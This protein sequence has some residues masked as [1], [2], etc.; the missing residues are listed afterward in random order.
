MVHWRG[1]SSGGNGTSYG[2]W[3]DSICAPFCKEN[4]GTCVVD[5]PNKGF[6]AC[7]N[8][9]ATGVGCQIK[10][11]TAVQYV[12]LGTIWGLSFGPDCKFLYSEQHTTYERLA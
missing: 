7:Q 5:G 4:K 12:V 9:R 11:S 10:N 2:I 1:S 8:S 6:C 3:F